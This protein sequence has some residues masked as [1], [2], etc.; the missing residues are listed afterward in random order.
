M[1][2]IDPPSPPPPPPP[3]PQIKDKK[4]ARFGPSRSFILDLEGGGWGFAAPFYFVQDCSIK[5]PWIFKTILLLEG[6][7]TVWIH[8]IKCLG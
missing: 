5:W 3:P 6:S 7:E 1:E 8:A 4:M 2:N